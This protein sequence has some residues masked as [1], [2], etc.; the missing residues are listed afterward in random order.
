M[1]RSVKLA[2]VARQQVAQHVGAHKDGRKRTDDDANIN[3]GAAGGANACTN[4][5]LFVSVM[6]RRPVAH[7]VSST[8]HNS[9]RPTIY[10]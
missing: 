1:Y 2:E 9:S 10:N 3:V 5:V 6:H 7:G 8:L 4:K